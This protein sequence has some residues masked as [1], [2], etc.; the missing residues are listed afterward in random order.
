MEKKVVILKSFNDGNN[1]Y[2]VLFDV[3]SLE[4]WRNDHEGI[5]LA[6]QDYIEEKAAVMA[7]RDIVSVLFGKEGNNL[8]RLLMAL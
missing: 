1:A 7:E 6:R 3:E 2:D 4:C 8:M 5:M